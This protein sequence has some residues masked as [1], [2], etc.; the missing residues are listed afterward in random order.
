MGEMKRLANCTTGGP[1]FVDVEGGKTV[2]VTPIDLAGDDKGDWVIEAQGKE[3]TALLRSTL[4]PHTMA[5][6][7]EHDRDAASAATNR[8]RREGRRVSRRRLH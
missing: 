4:S 7:G 2:R 5:S 3:S 1:V 6:N 8:A